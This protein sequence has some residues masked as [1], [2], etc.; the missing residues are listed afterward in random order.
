M[1]DN[2]NWK[3]KVREFSQDYRQDIPNIAGLDGEL[4]LWERLWRDHHNRGDP[5]PD[6]V[7]HALEV[8]DKQAFCNIYTI[9]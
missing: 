8:V 2:A 5:I 1:L 6:R 7:S 4:V 9:L 3:A